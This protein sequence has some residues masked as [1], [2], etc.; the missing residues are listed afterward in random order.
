[1][2]ERLRDGFQ[3]FFAMAEPVSCIAVNSLRLRNKRICLVAAIDEMQTVQIKLTGRLWPC[4]SS[5]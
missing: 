4:N 5:G 1:M 2:L 3:N